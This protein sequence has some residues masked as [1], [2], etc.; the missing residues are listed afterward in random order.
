MLGP[1]GRGDAAVLA[2]TRR[3]APVA[4]APP[5][6]TPSTPASSSSAARRGSGEV[7]CEDEAEYGDAG[8][9]RYAWMDS[10]D[11]DSKSAGSGAS[12]GRRKVAERLARG[13]SAERREARGKE[14]QDKQFEPSEVQSFPEMVRSAPRLERRAPDMSA[15]ELAALCAAAGR[16]KFYDASLF[17]A[18]AKRLSKLLDRS[19]RSGG[20]PRAPEIVTVVASLAKL[21]AYDTKL[22]T[23]AAR[24]LAGQAATLDGALAGRLLD[25]F[26]AV[27]HQGD[28]AFMEA[29]SL[30]RKNERYEAAKEE[31]HQRNLKRMYGESM[32]LQGPSEDAERAGVKIRRT[33]AL[34]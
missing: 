20:A 33:H 19:G 2:A 3:A 23:A 29:L 10:G 7:G 22:F 15:S 12:S 4:A 8:H 27:G 11:E 16:V 26:R 18:V 24:A 13:D 14:T 1:R 25:A 9:K 28:S 32:D 34:R 21:N 5:P 6:V 17:S 31:L 30:R